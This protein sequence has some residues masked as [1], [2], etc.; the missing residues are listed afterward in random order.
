VLAWPFERVI[1]AHG[2]PLEENAF[3]VLRQAFARYLRVPLPRR[4]R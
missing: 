2:E 3:D 1:A 4:P